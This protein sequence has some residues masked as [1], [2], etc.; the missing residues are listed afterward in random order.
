MSWVAYPV[1]TRA[2]ADVLKGM[3]LLEMLKESVE[4]NRLSEVKDAV[5]DLLISRVNIGVVGDRG[6][7]KTTLINSLLGLGPEDS[8]AAQFPSPAP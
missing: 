7:E 8:G 6:A 2:M 1:E 4:K 3:K 5:E